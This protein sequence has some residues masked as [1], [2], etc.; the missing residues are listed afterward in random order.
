[1]PYDP[2]A[3]ANPWWR[4]QQAF[5]QD[6]TARQQQRNANDPPDSTPSMPGQPSNQRP[7]PS[8]LQLLMLGGKPTYSGTPAAAGSPQ[9]KA[10][11]DMQDLFKSAGPYGLLGGM[12]LP[13]GAGWGGGG[14][15]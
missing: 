5:P 2:Y 9:A 4:Q 13:G 1:M 12:G 11:T 6:A 3:I 10:W 15:R 8:L 7:Q 14:P